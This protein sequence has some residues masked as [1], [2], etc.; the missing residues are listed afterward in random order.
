MAQTYL[1]LPDLITPCPFT[2]GANSH[3]E[4]ASAESVKWVDGYN[5]FPKTDSKRAYLI[6]SNGSLLASYVYP[7]ASYEDFRVCC[8]F[9]NL[10]FALDEIS[11]GHDMA[12]GY[13]MVDTFVKALNNKPCD[14]SLV[15]RITKECVRNLSPIVRPENSQSI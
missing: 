12:G 7:S 13:V 4:R 14:G 8:D 6:M 11:D 1:H 15:S 2:Q 5:I 9:M 10:L 3:F